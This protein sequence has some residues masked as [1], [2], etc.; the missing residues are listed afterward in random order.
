MDTGT[1]AVAATQSRLNLRIVGH[2]IDASP[3]TRPMIGVIIIAALA[4]LFDAAD[5]YHLGFAMPDIAKEFDLKS[6]TLGLIA[7]STLVGMCIGSFFWGWIAD[8]W[9]RKIAFTVTILMYSL[10]SGVSGLATGA[11][12]LLGAR[13]LTGIGIGGSV[14]GSVKLAMSRAATWRSNTVGGTAKWVGCRNWRPI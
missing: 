6:E 4:S 8:K 14:K 12:F 7:S 5:A 11:G 3:L 2:A 13:F 10:F 1:Q 9:G